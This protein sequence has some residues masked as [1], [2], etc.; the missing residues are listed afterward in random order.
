M[1]SYAY[2]QFFIHPNIIHLPLSTYLC[3][4]LSITPYVI[5]HFY[6]AGSNLP[7]KS[8][9]CW[10]TG[11]CAK[12]LIDTA[13]LEAIGWH[14]MAQVAQLNESVVAYLVQACPAQLPKGAC[15]K[16]LPA[17]DCPSL[18]NSSSSP[19][20]KFDVDA[21]VDV[22]VDVNGSGDGNGN[23]SANAH[24]NAGCSLLL[25]PVLMLMF[26]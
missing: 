10:G 12:Y 21:D 24:A 4:H 18:L 23:A 11:R 25:M 17:E 20:L 9:R 14:R 3:I 8:W 13:F 16:P 5:A 6:F 2:I 26:M 1:S 19:E 22:D 15:R 7:S